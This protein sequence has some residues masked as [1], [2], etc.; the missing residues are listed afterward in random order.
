M[1]IKSQLVTD[2][3]IIMKSHIYLEFSAY[4]KLKSLFEIIKAAEKY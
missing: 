3:I 2:A 1:I 4:K